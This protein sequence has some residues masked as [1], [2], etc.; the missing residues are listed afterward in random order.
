MQQVN[1][2]KAECR[3]LV[4]INEGSIPINSGGLVAAMAISANI[5]RD[6]SIYADCMV[7]KGYFLVKTNEVELLTATINKEK[8]ADATAD[9]KE[10]NDLIGQWK[11]NDSGKTGSNNFKMAEFDF[12]SGGQVAITIVQNEKTIQSR[13]T[14]NKSEDTI[15]QVRGTYYVSG[16]VLIMFLAT[17]PAPQLSAQRFT[18]SGDRLVIIDSNG[19]VNSFTSSANKSH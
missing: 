4:R 19:R 11:Y 16:D 13:G 6:K 10:A 5:D 2:D 1:M 12:S 7:S 17:T 8:P 3:N 18:L 15:N 9:N 14:S